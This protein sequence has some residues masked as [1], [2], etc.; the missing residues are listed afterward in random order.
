MRRKDVA[1]AHRVRKN[2][3]VVL[4]AQ[5]YRQVWSHQ[6]PRGLVIHLRYCLQ[7]EVVHNFEHV[8]YLQRPSEAQTPL[9]DTFYCLRAHPTFIYIC[10]DADT[11]QRITRDTVNSRRLDGNCLKKS[12]RIGSELGPAQI[13]I[14]T[15]HVTKPLGDL[16]S[17]ATAT[18]VLNAGATVTSLESHSDYTRTVAEKFIL[19]C[20][21][22]P[23][24]SFLTGPIQK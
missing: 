4:G 10:S 23:L 22:Y 9:V 2:F 8:R 16:V 7:H 18:M 20:A 3:I 6:V 1:N 24:K 11:Y 15:P 21:I 12:K 5:A 19:F 13:W 14:V 17:G